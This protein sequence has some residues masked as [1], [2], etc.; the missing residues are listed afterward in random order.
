MLDPV[1]DLLLGG[2]C[3][4]CARPGRALCRA[5]GELLPTTPWP[6]WPTPVPP[7]LATPWVAASY[8]GLVRAVLLAHKERHVAGLARP[9]AELLAAAASAAAPAPRL[10]VPVPSRPG[11]A[12]AR[13]HEPLLEVCRRAARLLPGTRLAPLLRSRGGV[14]DQAGLTAGERAANLVG[15]MWSPTASL[16]AQAGRQGHVVVCDDVLTTGSTVRE[17]QRALGSAGVDVVAVACIAA[18]ARRAG[19]R[20]APSPGELSGRRLSSRP[21]VD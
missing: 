6:A 4:G 20:P 1:L 10:L 14:L 21:D 15:S 18:T 12:R 3:V 7:G 17:A 13:G 9:L 5:C 16:R 19:R 11:A 8:D 2:S